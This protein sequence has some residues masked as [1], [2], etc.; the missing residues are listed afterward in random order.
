MCSPILA[1]SL[2][3]FMEKNFQNIL[4]LFKYTIPFHLL[5]KL[6]KQSYLLFH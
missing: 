2:S 6:D 5:L 4:N 1:Y 3:H